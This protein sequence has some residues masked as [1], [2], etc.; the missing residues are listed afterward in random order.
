MSG[1]TLF[2][3]VLLDKAIDRLLV[4]LAKSSAARKKRP[5]QAWLNLDGSLFFKVVAGRLEA[6]SEDCDSDEPDLWQTQ[7]LSPHGIRRVSPPN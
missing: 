3:G 2:A 4:L 1:Q 6:R 5:A 7:E